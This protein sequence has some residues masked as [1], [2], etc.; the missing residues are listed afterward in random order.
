MNSVAYYIFYIL[1]RDKCKCRKQTCAVLKHVTAG[2]EPSYL[3]SISLNNEL[4]LF[5]VCNQGICDYDYSIPQNVK[6]RYDIKCLCCKVCNYFNGIYSCSKL[7]GGCG[8]CFHEQDS[9]TFMHTVIANEKCDYI[10]PFAPKICHYKGVIKYVF[11]ELENK[12][13]L[14][15][16]CRVKYDCL[17]VKNMRAIP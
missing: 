11:N 5:Y 9:L 17:H 12:G 13:T 15:Y 4:Q 3:R 8:V 2:H 1:N 14:L 10:S 16:R 6:K 7:N